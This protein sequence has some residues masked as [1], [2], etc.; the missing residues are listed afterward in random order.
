MRRCW[1]K[2][3][4]GCITAASNVNCSVGRPGLRGLEH[5]RGAVAHEKS[6]RRPAG[7]DFGADDPA[8]KALTARIPRTR[9]G[10]T[11]VRPHLTLTPALEAALFKTFDGCGMNHAKAG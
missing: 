2:G 3:S 6:W 9:A 11:S 5:G 10:I 8:L 4:A 1:Q 7:G